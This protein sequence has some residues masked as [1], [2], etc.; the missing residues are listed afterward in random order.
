MKTIDIITTLLLATVISAEE[1]KETILPI[2][3]VT[4]YEDR[5]LIDRSGE[6]SLVAGI[7]QLT[8]AGLPVS[9]QEPS[10]RASVGAATGARILSV[11][12]RTEQKLETQDERLRALE[13]ADD[14][15]DRSISKLQSKM[16]VIND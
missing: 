3:G 6:V 7:N 10:L 2:K 9:L 8:I 1:A 15:L 16:S 14:E 13:K 4:L 5:A 12:S 11:S